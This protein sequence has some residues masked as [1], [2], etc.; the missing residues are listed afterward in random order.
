MKKIPF[1]WPRAASVTQGEP[2]D[3]LARR[4]HREHTQG[5]P[6]DPWRY[7]SWKNH[8]NLKR[9]LADEWPEPFAAMQTC[10]DIRQGMWE[11]KQRLEDGETMVTLIGCRQTP[12]CPACNDQEARRRAGAKLRQIVAATPEGE[13]V[14]AYGF[15]VAVS[16]P[17][18]DHLPAIAARTDPTR[19]REAVYRIIERMYGEGTGAILTYQHYGEAI[20]T[21][22]R[23]HVHAIIHEWRP[24]R[25]GAEKIE[26]YDIRGA[27]EKL[28][29]IAHEEMQAAFP[30]VR[31]Q[32]PRDWF[33]PYDLDLK[34]FQHRGSVAKAT[35]YVMRE[36]IDLRKMRLRKDG[37]IRI[38]H[39]RDPDLDVRTTPRAVRTELENY[40]RQMRDIRL[41]AAYG[42]MSNRKVKSTIEQI[43]R[44]ADHA[45][46]CWC[47]E[48]STWQRGYEGGV[49]A[50]ELDDE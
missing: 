31:T 5:N 27:R 43:G 47:H 36:L 7:D 15:T 23:P 42:C 17:T 45:E 13:E 11:T 30:E 33:G 10:R 4:L 35:K 20:L 22:P 46:G 19:F 8:W 34:F 25:N 41:H 6:A 12:Y 39:Y 16:S 29:E 50:P 3:E 2:P 40:Q 21:R 32:E 28:E 1:D 14:H 49:L 18:D 37:S 48:C 9:L 38:R 24:G 44:H 26:M